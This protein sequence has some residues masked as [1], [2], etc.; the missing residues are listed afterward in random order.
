LGQIPI[1]E[2][3]ASSGDSG[4]PIALDESSPVAK[5]F[6]EVAKKVKERI[7]ASQ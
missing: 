7:K 5:A 3:I 6:M 4:N 2:Q 1:V